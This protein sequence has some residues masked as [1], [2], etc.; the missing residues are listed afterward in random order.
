ML[1]RN[2]KDL[3]LTNILNIAKFGLYLE[4]IELFIWRWFKNTSFLWVMV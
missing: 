3:S 1:Y 4:Q 2:R